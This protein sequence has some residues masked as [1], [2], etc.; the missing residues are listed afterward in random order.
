MFFSVYLYFDFD[1]VF[2][3]CVCVLFLC[4]TPKTSI[5]SAHER[6]K[7]NRIQLD[8]IAIDEFRFT[9]STHATR[10]DHRKQ[11]NAVFAFSAILR[12]AEE[13]NLV[14]VPEFVYNSI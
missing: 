9:H 14:V 2:R 5:A 11:I 1:S 8:D 7:N 12:I 4:C 3:A 10:V 6:E 13:I